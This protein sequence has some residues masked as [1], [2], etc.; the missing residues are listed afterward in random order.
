M[1]ST[2]F[3]QIN[4]DDEF[5]VSG[6]E[7]VREEAGSEGQERL[8]PRQDPQLSRDHEDGEV[9]PTLQHQNKGFLIPEV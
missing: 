4:T 9:I 2:I 3:R 1:I 6:S 5:T 8:I 7:G